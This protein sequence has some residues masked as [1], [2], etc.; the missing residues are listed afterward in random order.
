MGYNPWGCKRSD[1][2][3]ATVHTSEELIFDLRC[4]E[5]MTQPHG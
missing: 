5:A 1:S 2:T 4:E 3:E